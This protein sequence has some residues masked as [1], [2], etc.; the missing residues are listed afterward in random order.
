MRL[1][2]LIVLSIILTFTFKSYGNGNSFLFQPSG[3]NFFIFGNG[4]NNLIISQIKLTELKLDSQIAQLSA[5]SRIKNASDDPAGLAVVEKINMLLNQLKRESMNAE[6]LRNL[7]NFIESSIA[8]DQEVINRI[9]LLVVQASNGILSPDDRGNI[10]SE[11]DQLINQI[12]LNAKFLQ[13]NCMGIIPQLTSLNL[14]LDDVDVVRNM[15]KSIKLVDEALERLTKD[16]VVRGLQSNLLTFQINGKNYLY[17]NLQKAES[18]MSD[19]DMAE[20]ITKLI[21]NSVLLKTEYGLVY[22][23][24]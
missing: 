15:Q 17:L 21:R 1:T 11:I 2:S 20:G 14:G 22:K 23:P 8:E 3:A 16:R 4:Q 12:N 9:R 18:S 5:G 19:L 10:Q 7:N 6:D 13:F 24:E